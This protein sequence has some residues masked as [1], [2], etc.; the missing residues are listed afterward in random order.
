MTVKFYLHAAASAV[1]GTPSGPNSAT[2]P[3]VNG[4]TGTSALSM[5]DTHGTF[6]NS[7]AVTSARASSQYDAHAL[8]VS[9]P[10]KAQIIPAGTWSFHGAFQTSSTNATLYGAVCVYVWD[11]VGGAVR[12]SLILDVT[13]AHTA[14]GGTSG[15]TASTSETALSNSALSGGSVTCQ[16]GDVLVCELWTY[17]TASMTG[18]YTYTAYYD[19]TTDDSAS[20]DA[21]YLTAPADLSLLPASPGDPYQIYAGPGT[22]GVPIT[23]PVGT[24]AGDGIVIS[25]NWTGTVGIS[26]SDTQGNT[27]LINTNN[28]AQAV[29]SLYATYNGSPGTPALPLTPGVDQITVS[30][31]TSGGHTM[32][33]GVPGVAPQVADAHPT[34][35][36]G[37]SAAP[38]GPATGTLPQAGDVIVY[39]LDGTWANIAAGVTAWG[40]GLTQ[41]AVTA[42]T[43]N[44]NAMAWKVASGTASDTPSATL[45]SS[46]IWIGMTLA[47]APAPTTTTWTAAGTA[48]NTSSASGAFDPVAAAGTASN[49]SQA[50]GTFVPQTLAGTASN[51]SSAST[52]LAPLTVAGSASNTS[53]ASGALVPQALS[54][55]ASNSSSASGSITISAGPTVWS[56]GG[57]ASNASAASA[58]FTPQTLAGTAS[59]TSSASVTVR[60]TEVAVGTASNASLASGGFTPQTLAGVAS[61]TSSA[62]GNATSGSTSGVAVNTS[63]ASV[64]LTLTAAVVGTASNTSHASG[65]FTPQILT[66]VASNTSHASGAFTPQ[67]LAGT[68]SN[69]SQASGAFTPQTLAGT[70]STTSHAFGAFVPQALTGI[71]ANVSH[72]SGAFL[73]QVLA[74]T[75][76]TISHA[77]GFFSPTLIAGTAGNVSVASVFVFS[78]LPFRSPQALG[79][80]V[81]DTNLLGGTVAVATIDGSTIVVPNI[82]GGVATVADLITGTPIGWTMQE[83]DILLAEF[84][85][86]TLNLTLTSGGGA[87]NIT[88]LEIDV[89][90]KTAAGAADSDPSTIKLSTATGE[91][92]ITSGPGGLANVA[93][94]ATDLTGLGIGFWRCDVVNGGKRNTAIYGTVTVTAL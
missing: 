83:I 3:D 87:L 93:I 69:A 76:V 85:D 14:T 26:A 44:G 28:T 68:S 38:S 73:A 74:G 70:A 46:E 43:G 45:A 53:V 32:I 86:E 60:L 47:L 25:A 55:T 7:A 33:A 11:P 23:V 42:G 81:L 59:N 82:L 19:G 20:T 71:A 89:F 49:T 8:F 40:D 65:A 16:D 18:A 24:Q 34:Y 9:P 78:G 62:S 57:A 29:A 17:S 51:T 2:S 79:G 50:S 84:N 30:G 92:T 31:G 75:A 66:G 77:F 48:S 35:L 56:A 63:T 1:T 61:N 36:N 22:T 5:D 12:G 91:V 94:P 41:I 72:A 37:T 52:T 15:H 39:I 58:G 6:Q 67:T 64:T 88:G 27:Y 21:A 90:L 13:A 80:T 10:L 54:G 4:I